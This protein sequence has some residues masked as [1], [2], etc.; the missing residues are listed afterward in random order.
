MR[1]YEIKQKS[2][3]PWKMLGLWF[4]A[5]YKIGFIRPNY[6]SFNY[7]I[8]STFRIGYIF[9]S[10]GTEFLCFFWR[11]PSMLSVHFHE[12]NF[13]LLIYVPPSIEPFPAYFQKRNT[14]NFSH[15][16]V[17]WEKRTQSNNKIERE[18]KQ[19]KGHIQ[20][21]TQLFCLLMVKSA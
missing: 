17:K 14:K 10:Y 6:K 18:T 13:I 2:A 20:V 5:F 1:K 8:I 3:C 11:S 9:H 19:N 7:N 21:F 16:K 12:T 15:G 4:V